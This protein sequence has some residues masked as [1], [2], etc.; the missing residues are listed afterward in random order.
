[1]SD[2]LTI[3]Q[4]YGGPYCFSS[5]FGSAACVLAA[6][7]KTGGIVFTAFAGGHGCAPFNDG[8]AVDAWSGLNSGGILDL[9]SPVD[10]QIV[11]PGT[12]SQATTSKVTVEAGFAADGDL[13]LSVYDS[14]FTLITSR[15]NG[16]DGL[17][18]NGRSL[19]T[20]SAAGIAFFRVSTPVV[21]TFGVDSITITTPAAAAGCKYYC[22]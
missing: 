7:Y 11:T 13:L 12:T 8:G 1:M 3:P 6:Q 15:V 18:P 5:V 16:L 20:I 2:I 14:S 21:D 22:N 10:V 9:V 17:G 19:I 4:S